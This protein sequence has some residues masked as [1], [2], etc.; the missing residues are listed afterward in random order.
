MTDHPVTGID[1]AFLLVDDLEAAAADWR[2]MG[3]TLSP[4]GLHSAAMGSANYT[5]M[6]PRDYLELLG[7]VSAVEGSAAHRRK[8][9]EQ[10][11]GLHAIAVRIEGTKAEDAT[12]RLSERGIATG[13]V[14]HFSRPVDL[15]GGGQGEAAFSIFPYAPEEIPQGHVFACGH[16]TRDT[17]WLPEL[18]EHPNGAQ[19]LDSFTVLSP[20]PE[21]AARG[22]ARL[23][24]HGEVS[25]EGDGF[26]VAT[27]LDSAV[28]R[29]LPREAAAALWPG[30][31]LTRLPRD[32][33]AGVAI[34][35]RDLAATEALLRGAG[36]N[37]A[38]LPSGSIALGPEATAGAV[39]E[40]VAD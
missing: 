28:L 31:D 18:L 21:K 11:Q 26:R 32:A 19:G 6:F 2:R 34:R 37:P 24:A 40:F 22:Y 14:Q 7:V 9:A 17:V 12:A 35:V 4:R 8:L 38:R 13:A 23:F 3:F 36:L 10:G 15:P 20:E 5:M 29:V 39:V 30:L 33:Y 27:G 16:H 25:A 1:H